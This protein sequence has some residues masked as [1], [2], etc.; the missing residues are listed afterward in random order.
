MTLDQVRELKA[1]IEGVLGSGMKLKTPTL[2]KIKIGNLMHGAIASIKPK[3]KKRTMDDFK[4]K[5]RESL[6]LVEEA[7]GLSEGKLDKE[8]IQKISLANKLVSA[9]GNGGELGHKSAGRGGSEVVS[10]LFGNNTTRHHSLG[11]EMK[12]KENG[13]D[14][15][16]TLFR[17]LPQH[18]GNVKQK[19]LGS[20]KVS[21]G[22]EADLIKAVVAFSKK[23]K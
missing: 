21:V 12:P 4:T 5:L 20:K 18:G 9:V 8:A 11:I 3:K 7:D 15:L 14:V 6:D 16:M 22:T 19:N 10:I 23:V 2:G 13:V 1:Y 17:Y